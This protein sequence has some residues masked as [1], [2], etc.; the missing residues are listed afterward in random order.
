M[1]MSLLGCI[2]IVFVSL[3]GLNCEMGKG[4]DEDALDHGMHM[5]LDDSKFKSLNDV[6]EKNGTFV[7]SGSTEDANCIVLSPI[8]FKYRSLGYN[9]RELDVEN[10]DLWVFHDGTLVDRT[11][12]RCEE[13]SV[14]YGPLVPGDFRLAIVAS[15]HGVVFVAGLELIENVYIEESNNCQENPDYY[16]GCQ[17]IAAEIFGGHETIVPVDM[18]CSEA[19]SHAIDIC[20]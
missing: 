2:V 18:F 7:F 10:V 11:V 5:Q 9:C 1:R 19:L 6:L 12:R 15:S 20:L 8:V 4:K 16:L 17:S 14:T 13:D 3:A